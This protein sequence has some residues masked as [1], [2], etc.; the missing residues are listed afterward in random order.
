MTDYSDHAQQVEAE[1][2]LCEKINVE[3]NEY[4]RGLNLMY[5][6][7]KQLEVLISDYVTARVALATI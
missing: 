7:R 6:Q 5:T 2:A 1:Q 4:I 3:L